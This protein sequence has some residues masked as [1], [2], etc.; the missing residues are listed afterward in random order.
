M[1]RILWYRLWRGVLTVWFVLTV[2]FVTPRLVG[3]PARS[4][5]P[6]DATPAEQAEL[7]ARLGLDLPLTR[8]Y[9]A[10][11]G[12]VLR[13]DFGESFAER[14]PAT[15]TVLERVPATLQLG[16]IALALSVLLGVGGGV[17]A[18]TRREGPWDR[19]LT[20]G[21]LVGQAVP[22]FVLGVA[23]I[24]VFS[25]ALRWLPSGGRE[26]WHSLVM[27]VAT[28]AAASSAW[29]LRLTR[30]VMLDLAEQDFV[31]TAHAKGVGAA[32][33]AL[34]HVLRNAC[35]PVLTLL[36]LRAGALVAGSVVVETVFAWPGVGRL[37]VHAVVTR[38][39]PVIQ[40]AVVLV[41][42]SVVVANLLVDLLYG[43]VDPRVR[44]S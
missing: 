36:G 14:R 11:L 2:A 44:T 18:A 20:A 25:L 42:V 6:E 41:S 21:A 40:F 28:L 26:G 1:A 3:D 27:P 19:L 35:L 30:G 43:V 32:S 12:N 5:L 31:R 13:G 34:K 33:V 37:L 7:R 9:V 22:N 38:D 8:Q 15:E 10:Y 29:L 16:G 24:L 17:L 39:F 4:L 23:L